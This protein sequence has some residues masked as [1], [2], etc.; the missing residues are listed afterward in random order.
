MMP[1]DTAQRVPASRRAVD[2]DLT[3][4]QIWVRARN[5]IATQ[6]HCSDFAAL[7]AMTVPVEIMRSRL[8]G[9]KLAA[10]IS[11][12]AI[13]PVADVSCAATGL[14]AVRACVAALIAAL[15]ILM[16]PLLRCPIM[17]CGRPTDRRTILD[18]VPLFECDDHRYRRRAPSLYDV[19]A[20]FAS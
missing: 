8:Q 6:K 3:S 7:A 20:R 13:P 14:A 17:R 11:M 12:A 5:E 19:T 4:D 15:G 16:S 1:K 9:M 10:G 18:I 2:S